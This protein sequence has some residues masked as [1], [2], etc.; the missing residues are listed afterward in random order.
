MYETAMK[1]IVSQFLI[2]GEELTRLWPMNGHHGD[3]VMGEP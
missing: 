1:I 3:G 2:A